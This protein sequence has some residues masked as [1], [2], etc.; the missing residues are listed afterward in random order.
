MWTSEEMCRI[1][2]KLE[3]KNNIFVNLGIGM[4]T[5]VANYVDEAMH[6]VFHS[7][8]GMLGMGP[9]PASINEVDAD[10]IN[11]GKQTITE[12]KYS[13]YFDSSISF[14]MVRGQHIDLSI[15]GALQVSELG[16][17]ANWTIPGKMMKGMGG[18]MDLVAGSKRVV[19]M[20]DHV[21]KE[22]QPKFLTK[23]SLP[24]TGKKVVDRLITN[25]AVFDFKILNNSLVAEMI[26][27]AKNISIAEIRGYTE[28]NYVISDS[29]ERL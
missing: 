15:L 29:L 16:D 27:A 8:N 2:A 6:V 25:M 13:S 1:A 24:L 28:A 3:M 17:L 22:K 23:C 9:S 20:M 19:V 11:A 12:L 21:N 5:Q 4:P 10:L 26:V 7:E 14:A 18:A